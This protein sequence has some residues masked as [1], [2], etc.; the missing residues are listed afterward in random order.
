MK[1]DSDIRRRQLQALYGRAG[2]LTASASGDARLRTAKARAT[3]RD[4][5]LAKVDPEGRLDPT[6]RVRRAEAA[7]R[8]HYV[9]MVIAREEKRLARQR[10]ALL[11]NRAASTAA[12]TE[13]DE[14]DVVEEL[15]R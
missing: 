10:P 11:R 8:L 9:R 1:Q 12:L 6:E 14:R 7:R 4:S 5:W 2:G 3:F 15:E 13:N